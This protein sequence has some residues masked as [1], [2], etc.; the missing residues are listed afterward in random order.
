MEQIEK[1][2]LKILSK[3]SKGDYVLIDYG[4]TGTVFREH[5]SYEARRRKEMKKRQY[6][7]A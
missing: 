4:C 3:N 6:C 2:R 5:Y 7:F 1:Y